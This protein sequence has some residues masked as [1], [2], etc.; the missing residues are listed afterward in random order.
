MRLTVLGWTLTKAAASSHV[1]GRSTAE[2][3]PSPTNP[4]VVVPLSPPPVAPWSGSVSDNSNVSFMGGACSCVSSS[5]CS[6]PNSGSD[7]RIEGLTTRR[8][9][10][11]LGDAVFSRTPNWVGRS[12]MFARQPSQEH[13]L[14]LFRFCSYWRVGLPSV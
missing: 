4:D 6:F 11:C 12:F 5:C 7:C 10:C 3:L 2:R 13:L 1:R 8:G 9:A 14:W